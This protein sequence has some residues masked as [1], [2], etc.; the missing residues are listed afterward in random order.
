MI[1]LLLVR[2]SRASLGGRG[3]RDVTVA[4]GQGEA[5][6]QPDTASNYIFVYE[7]LV[8]ECTQDL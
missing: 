6:T 5:S 8:S 1:V 7:R 3:G 2:A 4:G